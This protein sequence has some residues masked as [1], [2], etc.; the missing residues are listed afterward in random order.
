MFKDRKDAAI[1]LAKALEKYKNKNA[2]VCLAIANFNIYL[3]K[4]K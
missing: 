2:V 4:Q 1:Q 3:Y